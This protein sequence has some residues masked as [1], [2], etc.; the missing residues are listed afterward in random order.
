MRALPS[1]RGDSRE[2]TWLHRITVN[3]WK[4][5]LRARR[6][7]AFWRSATLGLVGGEEGER[8][9]R[10]VEPPLDAGL[11]KEER[12]AAVQKALLALEPDDR[13]IVVLRELEDASY[14]EIGRTLDLPQGTV[15]SRLFRARAKLKSLLEGTAARP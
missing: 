11:E 13:A 2:S 8:D 15:K 7:S 10:A 3:A 5:S 1:F 9:V 6:R 12:T 4:S 14:E